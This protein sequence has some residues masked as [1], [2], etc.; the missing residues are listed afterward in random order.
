MGRR[1]RGG[2]EEEEVE[3]RWLWSDGET[4]GERKAGFAAGEVSNEWV[5]ERI[6]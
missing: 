6:Q 4:A 1:E 5:D 3:T 2:E